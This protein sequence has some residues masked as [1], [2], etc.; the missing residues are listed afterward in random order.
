MP[1]KKKDAEEI[2]PSAVQKQV[3]KANKLQAELAAGKEVVPAQAKPAQA[4][5]PTPEPVKVPDPVPAAPKDVFTQAA[6]PDPQAPDESLYRSRYEVLKGKYDSE[7]P[8]LQTQIRSLELVMANMQQAMENQSR[9]AAEQ[10]PARVESGIKRLDP[11]NFE[12]YG[13][14]IVG[15][16]QGFNALLEQN[17]KLAA[18]INNQGGAQVTDLTK[19]T[20][21]L[22]TT[23]HK[24]VEDKYFDALTMGMEDWRTINRSPAFDNWLNGTDPISMANRR[25][26]LQYAANQ[27]NAQQVINIFKQFKLDSGMGSTPAPAPAPTPT[28]QNDHLSNQVMPGANL[29]NTDEMQPSGVQVIYPTTTEFSKASTD[30]VLKRITQAQYDDIANRYQMAIKANKVMA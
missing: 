23:I 16:A 13:G 25:D 28:I 6:I 27:M 29:G 11:T 14:E 4:T 24:T 18:M 1:K 5:H 3:D 19:R 22:E 7:I 15:M 8:A 20:E 26:I 30:F 12:E 17:E 2:V 21:Y 10:S 9:A